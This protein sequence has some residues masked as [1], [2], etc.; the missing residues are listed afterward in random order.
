MNLRRA[1]GVFNV[2]DVISAR[3][4]TFLLDPKSRKRTPYISQN[5][6]RGHIDRRMQ[7]LESNQDYVGHNNPVLSRYARAWAELFLGDYADYFKKNFPNDLITYERNLKDLTSEERD[8]VLD[9]LVD[10][11]APATI[12]IR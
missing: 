1:E 2:F 8:E 9:G 5:D 6:L 3:V 10:N 11:E 12:P 4:R 7:A